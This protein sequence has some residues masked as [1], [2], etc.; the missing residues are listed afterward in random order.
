MKRFKG[1]NVPERDINLSISERQY[2]DCEDSRKACINI[3]CSS[4]IFNTTTLD[5]YKDYL[6]TIKK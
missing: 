2:R 5:V 1:L 3:S 4:C 6:E